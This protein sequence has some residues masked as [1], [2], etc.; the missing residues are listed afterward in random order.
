MQSLTSHKSL[1]NNQY[2]RNT[3]EKNDVL[4]HK[5]FDIN[6]NMKQDHKN[7]KAKNNKEDK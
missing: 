4:S 1:G 3:V 5:K 2:P 7:P 6:K